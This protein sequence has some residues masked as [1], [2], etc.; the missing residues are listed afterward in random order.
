MKT[1]NYISKE[2]LFI[3]FR[4]IKW[5]IDQRRFYS[6]NF[7][8]MVRPYL[9]CCLHFLVSLSDKYSQVSDTKKR[10]ERDFGLENK[11]HKG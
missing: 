2:E 3:Y 6:S 4:Y 8:G 5:I 10:R 9:E 11:P 7:K 1:N